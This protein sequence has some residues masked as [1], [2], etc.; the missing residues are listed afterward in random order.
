[1]Q[2]W[3]VS[4]YGVRLILSLP[5]HALGSIVL[6]LPQPIYRAWQDGNPLIWK[7]HGAGCYSFDIEFDR[8]TEI[9]IETA[10]GKNES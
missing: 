6:A 2:N 3:Q 8:T 1:M 10:V 9:K 4:T 7:G 5:R